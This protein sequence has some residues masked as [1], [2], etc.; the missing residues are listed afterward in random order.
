MCVFRGAHVI[1]METPNGTSKVVNI[2][3]QVCGTSI[4]AWSLF[5]RYPQNASTLYCCFR[6]RRYSA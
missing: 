2:S 3:R 1:I 4:P 6:E 5:E